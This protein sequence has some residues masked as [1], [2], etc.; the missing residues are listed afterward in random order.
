MTTSDNAASPAASPQTGK[1]ASPF[2]TLP[3][4]YGIDQIEYAAPFAAICSVGNAPFS[5]E[6]VI[7]YQPDAKLLEFESF[8]GW[9]RTIAAER[10]TIESFGHRVTEALQSTLDAFFIAVK[11]VAKT[12]VHG[13]VVASL[14]RYKDEPAAWDDDEADTDGASEGREWSAAF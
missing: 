7:N 1:G 12:Q 11:V 10:H 4:P 5:G 3:N 2:S 14:S 9:L 8:E 13:P 6:V